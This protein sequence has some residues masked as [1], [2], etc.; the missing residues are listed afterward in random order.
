MPL[1]TVSTLLMTP[2]KTPPL[3]STLTRGSMTSL[4]GVMRTDSPGLAMSKLT[5]LS[6]SSVI[7]TFSTSALQTWST[8]PSILE[9]SSKT[10]S[11]MK[12]F[13][14]SNFTVITSLKFQTH[15]PWKPV[16]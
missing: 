3:P 12:I 2:G 9:A 5:L 6:F 15:M 1:P 7:A 11:V 14:S 10:M 4:T 16:F 8:P 13:P